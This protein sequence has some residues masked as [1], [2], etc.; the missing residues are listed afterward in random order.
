MNKFQNHIIIAIAVI[1]SLALI[2]S[3]G[4]KSSPS[5]PTPPPP[6]N[7]P[8]ITPTYPLPDAYEPDDIPAQA[9]PITSGVPQNKTIHDCNQDDWFYFTLTEISDVTIDVT[10]TKPM[11][12][13]SYDGAVTHTANGALFGGD[14]TTPISSTVTGLNPGTYYGNTRAWNYASPGCDTFIYTLSINIAAAG[15]PTETFTLS[16]TV[17]PTESVTE[18]NTPGVSGTH[19]PTQTNTISSTTTLTPTITQTQWASDAYEPDDGYSE[20]KT[21][22]AGSPQAHTLFPESDER[23][24]LIFHMDSPGRVTI[25]AAGT[26]SCEN[27]ALYLSYA[28]NPFGLIPIVNDYSSGQVQAT[29]DLYHDAANVTDDYYLRLE[30]TQPSVPVGYTLS[31]SVTYF[32]HTPTS[33]ITASATASATP[34]EKPV[35]D[36]YEQD[37][38]TASAKAIAAGETQPHS[39]WPEADDDYVVYN[40]PG[41]EVLTASAWGD[42]LSYYYINFSGGNTR[43]ES[44]PGTTTIIRDVRTPGPV[45]IAV[46]GS[47]SYGYSL[48]LEAIAMTPTCTFTNSPTPTNSPTMTTTPTTQPTLGS[49]VYQSS[50]SQS[51]ASNAVLASDGSGISSGFIKSVTAYVNAG[52]ANCS[53]KASSMGHRWLAKGSTYD[54]ITYADNTSDAIYVR[55]SSDL[56]STYGSSLGFGSMPCI[57]TDGDTPYVAYAD[58]TQG[59]SITVKTYSSGWVNYGAADFTPPTRMDGYTSVAMDGYNDGSLKLYVAYVDASDG[60]RPR[61]MWKNGASAWADL[62]GGFVSYEPSDTGSNIDISVVDSSHVY[63]IYNVSSNA[64][65]V[66]MWNGS[67]WVDLGVP[68]FP[69]VVASR[70]NTIKAVAYNEVYVSYLVLGTSK[71]AVRKFNGTSWIFINSD[72]SF[73]PTTGTYPFITYSGGFP[74][75]A[76]NDSSGSMQVYRYQ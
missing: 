38:D 41:D 29:Y 50:G 39:I 28:H 10:S 7:S 21:L 1:I 56:T 8:T 57:F 37:D 23:D 69:S 47:I 55:R 9:K 34:T 70:Y 24:W 32:T 13:E 27:V 73:T 31:Y 75:A 33:T 59:N 2:V 3:C 36:A 71:G 65:V 22:I 40:S 16:Q 30:N 44:T 60:N 17:S 35:E 46:S 52:S 25:T 62:G 4:P 76:Y 5:S 54:Y 66:H 63:V 19:T 67:S 53:L 74:Y 43:D 42:P 68:S 14:G 6:Y 20:A 58:S 51:A 72:S 11:Y 26:A 45:Y 61:V 15:V 48:K 49:W 12:L 64:A 18:T